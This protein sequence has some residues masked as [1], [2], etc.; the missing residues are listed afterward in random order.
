V[1]ERGDG[2]Q[3]VGNFAILLCPIRINGQLNMAF[4]LVAQ[5]QSTKQE[6]DLILGIRTNYTDRATGFTPQYTCPG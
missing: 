1:T 2:F 6:I 4:G 5:L 3:E